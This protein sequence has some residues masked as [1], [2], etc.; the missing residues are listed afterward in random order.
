MKKIAILSLVISIG[1][2]AYFGGSVYADEKEKEAC[3]EFRWKII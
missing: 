3:K 2:V 1:I